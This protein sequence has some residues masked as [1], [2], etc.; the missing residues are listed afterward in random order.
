MK[1]CY[2]DESGTGSEPFGVMVGVVV[3]AHR[4]RPTKEEWQKLLDELSGIV[5]QQVREIHTRDFYPGNGVWR[6]LDGPKRAATITA[7]IEWLKERKHKIVL[8]GVDKRRFKTDFPSE[9]QYGD[10]KTLWRF[11]GLHL[12]L[13]LQKCH[14]SLR[15]NKGNTVLVF[16]REDTEAIHFTDLISNPPEWT[17]TYYGKKKK[18]DRLDQVID[19]P[20]FADSKQVGLLQVADV[21]AFFLRRHLEIT[22]AE[23]PAR[24]SGED[25]QIEG[26]VQMI[27][28]Q[29]ITKSC[30]YMK[31][32]RCAAAE[33]FYSYAPPQYSS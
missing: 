24:F 5:G 30:M 10:I 3:D 20:F 21:V 11:M 13:S 26:W 29:T 23:V 25:T 16:D 33:L 9:P 28:D 2:I 31:R 22:S 1:F 7:I 4:M 32:G 15:S 14:Q 27:L 17:D 12:V 19:V 6:G 18:K 8:S